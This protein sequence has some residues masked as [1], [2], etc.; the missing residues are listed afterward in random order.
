MRDTRPAHVLLFGDRA[1]AAQYVQQ[2]RML[3]GVARI[4]GLPRMA[5]RLLD[6]TLIE[7]VADTDPPVLSVTAPVPVAAGQRDVFLVYQFLSTGPLLERASDG[8]PVCDG[9]A[10]TFGFDA[11]GA[12]KAFPV[13]RAPDSL[14]VRI[15][16]ATVSS[17][18]PVWP[19]ADA[20]R[21]RAGRVLLGP[22]PDGPV[23]VAMGAFNTGPRARTFA[24]LPY[25]E[26]QPLHPMWLADV[27]DPPTDMLPDGLDAV[28]GHGMARVVDPM[29][30]TRDFVLL[31]DS[32]SRLWIMPAGAP[33]LALPTEMALPAWVF[34]G[35]DDAPIGERA[36][37]KWRFRPDGRRALAVVFERFAPVSDGG[38][39]TVMA[40][41]YPAH[42]VPT[43]FGDVVPVRLDAAGLVEIDIDIRLT[44]R[45]QADFAVTFALASARRTAD[46]DAGL[47]AADY[48][49]ADGALV[50][51][52][53]F[54]LLA[55]R[56]PRTR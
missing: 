40:P 49:R 43:A 5:R 45:R 12:L 37:Y 22:R 34:R 3:L 17:P 47:L 52:L 54:L 55:L 1:L 56:Q 25:P 2:A 6:G 42:T 30:G 13:R 51:A 7:V 32:Y 20:V 26:T 35:A 28:H 46:F 9:I 10:V 19:D 15:E 50:L 8:T 33:R 53:V 23:A 4:V 16:D 21:D 29:F 27:G 48:A 14:P 31:A 39:A 41:G 24:G 18:V 11:H 36:A 44:G 38:G